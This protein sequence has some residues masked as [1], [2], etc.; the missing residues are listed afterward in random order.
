S[1]TMAWVLY[2]WSSMFGLVLVAEFWLLANDL[3]NAREA[4]RL[5]PVIGAGAILGGTFGGA[6]S[7]WLAK[8]LG[9]ANLL[10]LVAAQL[11][12]ASLLAHLAWRRRPVELRVESLAPGR[13]TGLGQGFR[14]VHGHGY[15][16]LLAAMMALMTLCATF[17]Q[18]QWKGI[19]KAH[20]G[21]RSD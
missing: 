7:G 18:W 4:K 16:R 20:F 11:L 10:H 6:L 14:I 13:Q 3:F 9:A 19:A 15:V 8:P 2:F 21:S 5:F 1:G 17:V 12:L